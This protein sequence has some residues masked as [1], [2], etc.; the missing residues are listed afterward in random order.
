MRNLRLPGSWLSDLMKILFFL[1]LVTALLT[2]S[3]VSA[4]VLAQIHKWLGVV[5]SFCFFVNHIST[6]HNALLQAKRKYPKGTTIYQN[7]N[8]GSFSRHRRRFTG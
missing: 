5:Y 7:L 6:G 1:V 3:G 4:M 8:Q 2:L